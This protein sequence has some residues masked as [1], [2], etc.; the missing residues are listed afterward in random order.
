MVVIIDAIVAP[1]GGNGANHQ[2]KAGF[3]HDM[4]ETHTHPDKKEMTFE[5]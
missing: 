3:F 4:D 2:D 5:F 1:S